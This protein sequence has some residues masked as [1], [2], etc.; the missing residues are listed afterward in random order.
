MAFS[1]VL[2][3]QNDSHNLELCSENSECLNK[4]QQ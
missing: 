4:L 1:E 3:D 2:N